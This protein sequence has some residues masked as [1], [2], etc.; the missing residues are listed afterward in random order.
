MSNLKLI[1]KVQQGEM[2]FERYMSEYYDL[3]IETNVN[4]NFRTVRI[5]AL[6]GDYI[7]ALHYSNRAI[8]STKSDGNEDVEISTRSYGS[9]K[10][11]E[12]AKVIKG[13]EIAVIHVEEIKTILGIKNL[14]MESK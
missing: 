9:L 11:E 8:F 2:L 13:Y 5:S 10:T 6:S 4:H 1:D 3:R 7:P 14:Q 12:I